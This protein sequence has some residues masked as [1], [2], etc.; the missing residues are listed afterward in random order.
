MNLRFE[1]LREKVHDKSSIQPALSFHNQKNG[2]AMKSTSEFDSSTGL[3]KPEANRW[4][5]R[6][7]MVAVVAAMLLS[8]IGFV[9][10]Y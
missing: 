6:V 1:R 7:L 4:H 5:E 8:L 2:S 10:R 3:P 9:H